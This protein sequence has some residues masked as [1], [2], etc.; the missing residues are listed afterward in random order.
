MDRSPIKV[1]L[2]DDHPLVRAGIRATL[3]GEPDLVLVG[4]ADNGR[5]ARRFAEDV[6]PDVLLLDLSMP[7]GPAAVETVAYLREN[8]PEVRV[9]I[10]TAYYDDAY[11]RGLI[12]AGVAG[13]ILKDEVPEA[14]VRAL[15]AVAQGGTWF[16]RSMV[17]K[18]ALRPLTICPPLRPD[19][20]QPT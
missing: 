14:V 2:A 5:D 11:I 16:S 4:E 18:L 7:G 1:L 15:H 17:A 10:L 6:R 9:V 8:C 20:P 3:C 13:Y 12:Q 19:A